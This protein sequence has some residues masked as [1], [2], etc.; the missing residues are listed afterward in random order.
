M[1]RV[2][3]GLREV[4]MKRNK[5][6][7]FAA[8]FALTVIVAAVSLTYKLKPRSTDEAQRAVRPART[9]TT[10]RSVQRDTAAPPQTFSWH[11]VESADYLRYVGNLRRV[12]CPEATVDDIVVADVN[13][14]YLQKSTPV[15]E[16]IKRA[17]TR[18]Y[19]SPPA[20]EG[21][22]K[23]RAEADAK[24]E[25]LNRERLA[26][27]PTILGHEPE[28]F[29][30]AAAPWAYLLSEIITNEFPY[31]P[32]EKSAK[33]QELKRLAQEKRDARLP[34]GSSVT[35]DDLKFMDELRQSLRRDVDAI[36]TPAELQEYLVH[37]SEEADELQRKLGPIS[38]TDS[39][40][41]TMLGALLDFYKDGYY[42]RYSGDGK[43]GPAEA[44]GGVRRTF[45]SAL[46]EERFD[47][48]QRENDPVYGY[49]RAFAQ[50]NSLSEEQAIQAYNVKKRFY[51][52]MAALPSDAPDEASRS[53]KIG[54]MLDEAEAS[55][56]DILADGALRD[57]F[58]QSPGGF[59]LTR[60][61]SEPGLAEQQSGRTG[62]SIGGPGARGQ[63]TDFI[64]G[65]H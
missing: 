10:E 35:R 36:L 45:E 39:E 17:A 4:F 12:G 16:E 30:T 6:L 3:T 5:P 33:V 25:P 65:V 47:Q 14:L 48:Y 27:L 9:N 34:H 31:L 8:L 53:Q 50:R 29:K 58:L 40:F 57:R 56:R 2:L 49:I 59:W 60:F 38:V 51:D 24:L 64:I 62:L 15:L 21:K 46:G 43:S 55:L 63:A 1:S 44:D 22:S 61:R 54:Q 13:A 32:L 26:L 18:F 11:E 28:K 7:Q 41:R 19:K 23:M 42:T 52:G 20:V 37:N